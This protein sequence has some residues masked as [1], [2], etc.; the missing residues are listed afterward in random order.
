MVSER[1]RGWERRTCDL[2]A[3][4][5]SV[6]IFDE[7][8]QR[9]REGYKKSVGVSKSKPETSWATHFA[10]SQRARARSSSRR[11]SAPVQSCSPLPSSSTAPTQGRTQAACPQPHQH[12]APRS[13]RKR[14]SPRHR[15]QLFLHHRRIHRI[16]QP[17]LRRPP[18]VP[19]RLV[20]LLEL[21][22]PRLVPL[23]LL[24]ILKRRRAEL[25][26]PRRLVVRRLRLRRLGGGGKG[27]LGRGDEKR[28]SG[29]PA[30]LG[31][32]GGGGG[33]DER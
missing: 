24:R 16:H 26:R 7:R 32:S 11:R 1:R 4:L 3:E 30:S 17:R 2:N 23:P 28:G 15:R 31:S 5:D 21:L 27:G 14:N 9:G 20:L 13:P 19:K 12:S 29:E 25:V 22:L 6:R 33:V 18:F 8:L 10:S